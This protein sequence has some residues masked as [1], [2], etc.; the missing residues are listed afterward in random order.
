MTLCI[1][2][3]F[4]KLNPSEF[5]QSQLLITY[6]SPIT[7]ISF[8]NDLDEAGFL[9]YPNKI[10]K[11]F[12]LI[13]TIFNQMFTLFKSNTIYVLTLVKILHDD[14]G[15]QRCAHDPINS[16]IVYPSKWSNT[17]KQFLGCQLTNCLSVFDHFVGLAL[18][19]LN[20]YYGAFSENS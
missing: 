7:F 6:Q 10:P 11:C 1:F 18:R 16:L 19:G 8:T 17:L 5:L 20:I 15:F 13:L 4:L 3:N 14:C 2:H 12:Q 9:K